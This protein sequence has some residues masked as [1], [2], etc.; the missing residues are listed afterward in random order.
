MSGT[1]NK[2]A[3]SNWE[4][5]IVNEL[6]EIGFKSVVTSRAESRNLD[7][8]KVDVFCTENEFPYYIQAKCYQNYPKLNDLINNDDVCK[9]RPMLVFHQK[10]IKKGTRF[11]TEDEFVSM[12]KEV[13]YNI[14]K[15][16]YGYK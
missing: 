7:N 1:R 15:Q 13:F 8:K 2:T 16:L 10:T 3:G 4:R 6:K 5:K 12:K 14:L 9:K 11:Y